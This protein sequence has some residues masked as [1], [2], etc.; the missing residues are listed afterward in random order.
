[1]GS[2][3]KIRDG[4]QFKR[5][6]YSYTCGGAKVRVVCPQTAPQKVYLIQ[7]ATKKDAPRY[8]LNAHGEPGLE[9][10]PEEELRVPCGLESECRR[11]DGERGITDHSHTIS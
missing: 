10:L 1:M 11:R 3:A 4:S 9:V 5:M 8:H 6:L 7:I 2:Q